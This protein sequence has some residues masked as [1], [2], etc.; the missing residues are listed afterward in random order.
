MYVKKIALV[1]QDGM[2]ENILELVEE[3]KPFFLNNYIVST[4]GTAEY[5]HKNM[6]IIA[7]D[8]VNSGKDGGDISIANMVLEDNID[9]VIFLLNPMKHFPHYKDA[10]ALMW[11]CN[12]K[13]VP[14]ATNVETADLLLSSLICKVTGIPRTN[15]TRPACDDLKEYCRSYILKYMT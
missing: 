11:M 10:Y 5:L 15:V 13:N 3:H 1:A 2:K 12:I 6:K 7:N 14:L 8:V 4:F 9:I